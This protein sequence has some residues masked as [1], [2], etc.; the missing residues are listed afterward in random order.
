MARVRT[1]WAW[2]LVTGLVVAAWLVLD[3]LVDWDGVGGGFRPIPFSLVWDVGLF[4]VPLPLSLAAGLLLPDSRRAVRLAG[5]AALALTAAV[6]LV[7]IL[8]LAFH[9]CLDPGEPCEP[10]QPGRFA[11]LLTPLAVIATGYAI[12]RRRVLS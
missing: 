1:R 10:T 9:L 8:L 4:L 3:V 11:H 12:A 6:F 2:G 5:F 7:G